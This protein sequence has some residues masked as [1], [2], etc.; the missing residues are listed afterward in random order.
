[1]NKNIRVYGRSVIAFMSFLWAHKRYD[2][3]QQLTTDAM[4]YLLSLD[5]YK[6]V[7]TKGATSTKWSFCDCPIDFGHT[8]PQIVLPL[9]VKAKPDNNKKE[10]CL[11]ESPFQN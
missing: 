3:Y 10:F 4:Y 11:L 1:M 6:L 5:C 8:D 2:L 9:G 7:L